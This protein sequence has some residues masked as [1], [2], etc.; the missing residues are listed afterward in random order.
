MP[1][2]KREDLPGSEIPGVRK[3]KEA[4]EDLGSD[5]MYNREFKDEYSISATAITRYGAMFKSYRLWFD[6]QW[7]WSGSVDTIKEL[8]EKL[9]A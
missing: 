2:H 4:L 8:E 7:I 5:W 1:K 9:R 3:I 6:C